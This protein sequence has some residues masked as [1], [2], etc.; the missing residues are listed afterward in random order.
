MEKNE[1]RIPGLEPISSVV[2]LLKGE[3]DAIERAMIEKEND[4]ELTNRLLGALHLVEAMLDLSYFKQQGGYPDNVYDLVK[5]IR[6]DLDY[7]RNVIK[8]GNLQLEE[9]K[10]A[11]QDVKTRI[12]K[13]QIRHDSDREYDFEE[14]ELREALIELKEEVL[15]EV[16]AKLDA[17]ESLLNEA[18][19]KLYAMRALQAYMQDT[20]YFE[21]L[22]MKKASK[23]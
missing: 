8:R 21:R 2:Y 5:E 10:K 15:P 19:Q 23:K 3:K 13:L 4:W 18:W 7:Q 22:Y 6:S 17:T 1:H 12:A 14:R 11:R 20:R 16:Q 9:A